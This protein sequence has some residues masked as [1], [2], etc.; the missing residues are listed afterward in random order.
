MK[1]KRESRDYAS[2]GFILESEH[3]FIVRQENGWSRSLRLKRDPL[4]EL[5][6][7]P[8]DARHL[9]LRLVCVY[10]VPHQRLQWHVLQRLLVRRLQG[11]SYRVPQNCDEERLAAPYTSICPV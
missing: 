2:L 7:Q 6:A 4:G 5:G 3:R 11:K 8:I 1:Q 10:G 9:R